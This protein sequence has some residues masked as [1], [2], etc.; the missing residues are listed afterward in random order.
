[1]CE[2]SVERLHSASAIHC[3]K[4]SGRSSGAHS[5]CGRDW[6]W[7]SRACGSHTSLIA[8]TISHVQVRETL[9]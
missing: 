7:R 5:G 8:H 4:R 1:M 2:V 3:S 6:V 9:V